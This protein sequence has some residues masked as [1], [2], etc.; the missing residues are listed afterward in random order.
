MKIYLRKVLDHDVT[1][2]VSITKDVHAD[3]FD[4]SSDLE[5]YKKT[6]KTKKYKVTVNN[7]TDRRFGG[8]FKSLLR[9]LGDI[10]TN[11]IIVIFKLSNGYSVDLIKQNDSK[12]ETLSNMFSYTQEARHIIIDTDS[13]EKAPNLLDEKINN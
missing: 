7:A 12:Y 13:I 3:F 8:E 11:D 4:N 6:E 1:H 5:F 9:D 10:S 2:E